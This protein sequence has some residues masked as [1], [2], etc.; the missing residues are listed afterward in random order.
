M[1]KN[2]YKCLIVKDL[3]EDAVCPIWKYFLWIYLRT[4]KALIAITD[5]TDSIG[6]GAFRM[7]A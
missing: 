2:V 7:Q 6:I 1:R 3:E 4:T 5:S